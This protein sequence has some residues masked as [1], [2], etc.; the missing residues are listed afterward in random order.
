MKYQSII[1]DLETITSVLSDTK[2]SKSS[3]IG[4]ALDLVNELSTELSEHLAKIAVNRS[5][6]GI[7][8]GISRGKKNL[9]EINNV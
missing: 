4:E 1:T 7:A 6:A 8:S 9:V 5:K 2:G 3:K